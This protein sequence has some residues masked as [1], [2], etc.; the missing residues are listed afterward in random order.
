MAAF[1]PLS[2]L[3]CV[4]HWGPQVPYELFLTAEILVDSVWGACGS[5]VMWPQRHTNILAI[6]RIIIS[7]YMPPCPSFTMVLLDSEVS[8]LFLY[9]CFVCMIQCRTGTTD[10]RWMIISLVHKRDL[11]VMT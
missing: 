9:I 6:I 8:K 10:A 1:C 3:P 7:L 11:P 2:G 4:D 5:P